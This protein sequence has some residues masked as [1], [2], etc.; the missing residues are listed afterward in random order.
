MRRSDVRVARRLVTLAREISASKPRQAATPPIVAVGGDIE[1]LYDPF[2]STVEIGMGGEWWG[3]KVKMGRN[4]YHHRKESVDEGYKPVTLVVRRMR[5]GL[6]F[7]VM[8]G[9][10]GTDGQTFLVEA[11]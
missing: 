11:R 10:Y 8:G 5:H 2:S 1:F 6:A 9:F 7:D 3:G 4:V